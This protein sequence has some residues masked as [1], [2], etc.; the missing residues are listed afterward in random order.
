MNL[1]TSET[2]AAIGLSYAC[3]QKL[4]ASALAARATNRA[5]PS[6]AKQSPQTNA[7]M[8]RQPWP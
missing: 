8:L 1:A 5:N 7:L 4:Q 3:V 2:D 6:S